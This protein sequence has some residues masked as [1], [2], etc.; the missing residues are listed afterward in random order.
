MA[1]KKKPVAKDSKKGKKL[2]DKKELKKAQTLM[3]HLNL[4]APKF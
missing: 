2:S 4:R 3:V 1:K